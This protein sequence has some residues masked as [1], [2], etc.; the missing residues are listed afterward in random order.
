M[1]DLAVLIFSFSILFIACS[2][3]E[4]ITEEKVPNL[5]ISSNTII[6]PTKETVT[7][8]SSTPQ[9]TKLILNKQEH[10]S[11]I[12]SDK[13]NK[14]SIELYI[15]PI[16]SNLPEYNRNDWKHWNDQDGDCQNTRHEV[17]IDESISPVKF[18]STDKC[19][20]AYGEWY[21]P[22]TGETIT[23]A[24]KLDVDHMVPLKNAHDSGGWKW[25][26]Q[27]K[28]EYANYMKY[29]DHLIAVTASANRQKGAKSPDQWVPPNKDNWCNYAINWV[30]IKA[31]WNLTSTKSEFES[32]EKMIGNCEYPL[33]II[34]IPIE[35]EVIKSKIVDKQAN[36][37]LEPDSL[38]KIE[39][40]AIDCKG[41]PESVTVT[42][43]GDSDYWFKD[44]SIVDEGMKHTF[45]FPSQFILE[46]GKS[47]EI[48]S[49]SYV[50]N[51][52]EMLYWKKQSVWNNDGD[53]AT[54]LDSTG[55]VVSEMHCP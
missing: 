45:N 13:Y 54:L 26:N 22:F 27:K 17:L 38:M 41:T 55:S 47:V 44:W 52:K 35:T 32:L 25:D 16:P 7:K 19:Q 48:I 11:S 29:A 36:S 33:S 14:T 20:V 31:K 8:I 10:S 50:T 18:K 15:S 24:T 3:G 5:T 49:G 2:S 51:S 12:S 1:K 9:P 39:I 42:N 28:S 46:T 23:D 53:T 43:T 6:E 21:D 4:V 40:S 37:K 30:E 34:G